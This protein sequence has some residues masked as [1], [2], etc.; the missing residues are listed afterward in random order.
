MPLPAWADAMDVSNRNCA[1]RVSVALRAAGLSSAALRHTGVYPMER[2]Y[3]KIGDGRDMVRPM[4]S[5][6]RAA[7]RS[8]TSM[9][10]LSTG[11]SSPT[12]LS[13]QSKSRR[14]EIAM[15]LRARPSGG[16]RDRPAEDVKH[17]QCVSLS[18][19]QQEG[20]LDERPVG[21]QRSRL[22][23]CRPRAC[24]ILHAF[25]ERTALGG[26]RQQ[27]GFHR[28]R[29]SRRSRAGAAA[30]CAAPAG[31]YLPAG[32]TAQCSPSKRSYRRAQERRA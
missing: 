26:D 4:R 30:S 15:E 19:A 18:S 6:R 23:R 27:C 5:R 24:D 32:A 31:Q 12:Q 29:L 8:F 17:D 3:L 21:H 14:A 22:W 16:E 20:K 7:H 9:K 28:I 2:Y 1:T 25:D 10:T 13:R 11:R